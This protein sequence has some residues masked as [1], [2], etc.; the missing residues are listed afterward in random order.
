MRVFLIT[1]SG[2]IRGSAEH[3]VLE[4]NKEEI[5]DSMREAISKVIWTTESVGL[6]PECIDIFGNKWEYR[7]P[8][9]KFKFSGTIKEVVVII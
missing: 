2:R 5:E 7:N 3:I 8:H 4:L 9:S 6:L 1:I